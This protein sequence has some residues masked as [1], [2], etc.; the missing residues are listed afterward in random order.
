[1]Q[2]PAGVTPA[3]IGRLVAMLHCRTPTAWFD[4]Y[5]TALQTKIPALQDVPA[6]SHIWTSACR[7][8]TLFPSDLTHEVQ[9]LFLLL[10][11]L[12]VLK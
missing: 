8:G 10:L 9:Q 4:S 2:T 1:M 5:R 6:T 11:N 12:L 7:P 3:Q